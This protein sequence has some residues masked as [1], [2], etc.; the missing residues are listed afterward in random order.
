MEYSLI[1]LSSDVSLMNM[2]NFDACLLPHPSYTSYHHFPR[3]S[4]K[5]YHFRNDKCKT[6]S[7]PHTKRNNF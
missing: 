6:I 7:L 2:E 3:I 5:V 1:R 4:V